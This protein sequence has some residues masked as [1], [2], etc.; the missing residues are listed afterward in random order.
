M[1]KAIR[2]AMGSGVLVAGLA[3]AGAS[4]ASAQVRVGGTVRLPHGDISFSIGDRFPIGGYVP[5]GY[6]VYQDVDYGYG[7]EYE[8]QWIPCEPRGTR[9]VIVGGPV[10]YGH[11]DYG[12]RDY[13]YS[14]PYRDYRYSRPHRNDRYGYSR[15]NRT[16]RRDGRNY[17]RDDRRWRDDRGSRRNDRRNGGRDRRW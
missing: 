1:T 15:D 6:D 11:R 5:Y 10:F 7:F 16:Y 14:R 4:S 2:I 12:Y 9:W 17:R 8:D 3:I 13:R